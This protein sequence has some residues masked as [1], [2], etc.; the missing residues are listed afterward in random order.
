MILMFNICESTPI[1]STVLLS[2]LLCELPSH[3]LYEPPKDYLYVLSEPG[4]KLLWQNYPYTTILATV[5]P[6]TWM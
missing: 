3:N 2:M 5:S 1:L 4:W 6:D